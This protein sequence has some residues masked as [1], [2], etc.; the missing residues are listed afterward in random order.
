MNEESSWL[1]G[2][3]PS[4]AMC[5]VLSELRKTL[6]LLAPESLHL[7]GL[8]EEAQ[9]IANRMEAGLDDKRNYYALQKTLRKRIMAMRFPEQEKS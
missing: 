7:R 1:P 3:Y 2:G 5:D 6:K 4:R 9:T 8:V